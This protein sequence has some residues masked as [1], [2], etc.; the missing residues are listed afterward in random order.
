M[1]DSKS[2]ALSKV[3]KLGEKVSTRHGGF[4]LKKTKGGYHYEGKHGPLW[5]GGP[6]KS[7]SE[8]KKR[9]EEFK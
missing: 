2:K 9:A 3:K 4:E 6:M 5:S 1:K 7:Y 8:A